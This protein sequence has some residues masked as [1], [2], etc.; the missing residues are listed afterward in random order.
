MNDAL[1]VIRRFCGYPLISLDSFKSGSERITLG[2]PP[3]MR[4][5]IT[6]EHI[7]FA[8][9]FTEIWAGNTHRSRPEASIRKLIVCTGRAFE[10]PFLFVMKEFQRDV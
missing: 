5:F 1:G 10:W 4:A 3:G 2:L 7:S 6:A 8:S 9:R